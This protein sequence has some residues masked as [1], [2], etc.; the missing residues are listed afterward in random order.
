LTRDT[1]QLS[2]SSSLELRACTFKSNCALNAKFS[3]SVQQGTTAIY[4]TLIIR[5]VD[6]FL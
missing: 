6:A 2:E 5:R 1:S 4:A 3:L